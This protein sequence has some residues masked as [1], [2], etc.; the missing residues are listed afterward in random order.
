MA[1]HRDPY[2]IIGATAYYPFSGQGCNIY[3]K[4]ASRLKVIDIASSWLFRIGLPLLL[5]AAAIAA[6]ANSLRLYTCA[7]TKYDVA[8]SLR[9]ADEELSAAELSSVYTDLIRYYNSG[10]E[11]ASLTI[12]RGRPEPFLTEEETYHFKDVKGLIR[13]DYA[14]LLGAL[15][16]MLACGGF[17]L[18]RRRWRDLAQ[19][20]VWGGGLTLGF[21]LALLLLNTVSSFDQLF[22]RFHLLFFDNE[23]WYA[24]GNMLLLFPEGL[25]IDAATYGLVAIALA[26][27]AIGGVGLWY[28]RSR[29]EPA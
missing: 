24:Q 7:A 17:W 29:R 18:A 14:I 8:D 4:G 22:Y 12:D 10:D 2:Y 25:F 1:E 26:A 9:R 6:G 20:A 16:Y 11:H 5:L 15:L 21:I 27:L 28:L 19:G 23:F 3:E 13:L